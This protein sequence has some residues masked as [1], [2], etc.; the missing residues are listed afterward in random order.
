MLVGDITKR[1]WMDEVCTASEQALLDH[2][3]A[4]ARIGFAATQRAL[5]D[6]SRRHLMAGLQLFNKMFPAAA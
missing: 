4:A 2:P 6:Y 1:A 5:H 3:H